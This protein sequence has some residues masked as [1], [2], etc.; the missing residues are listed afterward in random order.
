[1]FFHAAEIVA[2][3]LD[4]HHRSH[5][6]DED[7]DRPR[8]VPVDPSPYAPRPVEPGDPTSPDGS[9]L[10]LDVQALVDATSP[11]DAATPRSGST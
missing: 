3:D 10:D 9:V 6:H 11:A 5:D 8:P 1:M 4:D 7:H 2:K